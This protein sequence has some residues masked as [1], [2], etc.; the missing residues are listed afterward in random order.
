MSPQ[1]QAAAERDAQVKAAEEQT[2]KAL[3]ELQRHGQAA[4]AV[5]QIGGRG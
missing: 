1:E 3:E 4:A 2:R 5:S